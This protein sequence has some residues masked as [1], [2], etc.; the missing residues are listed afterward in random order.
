MSTPSP[1]L[2]ALTDDQIIGL[3]S[4]A[5]P[6]AVASP[7]ATAPDAPVAPPPSADSP[8]PAPPQPDPAPNPPADAEAFRQLYPGGIAEARAAADRARQLDEIDT[9]YFGANSASPQDLSAARAQLAQKLFAQDPA[10]FR[11]MVAA[12]VKLLESSSAPRSIAD[13]LAPTPSA[14]SPAAPQNSPALA[15]QLAQQYSAFER[16]ANADLDRSIGSSISRT[17]EQ[18]LPNLAHRSASSSPG[19]APLQ[20]RLASAVREELDAALR[21]DSQLGDQVSRVLASRRFDDSSRAQVVRLIDSRAQ[22]LVPTVVRRVVSDWT[23]ATLTPRL[24][25]TTSS[26]PAASPQSAPPSPAQ[27]SSPSTPSRPQSTS[28]APPPRSR[29]QRPDYSTLSDE[30]ILDL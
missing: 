4:S 27:P 28:S 10:A 25:T 21:S 11:E 24:P 8:S 17:L 15:P 29:S 2:F 3:D 12:G 9:V 6:S 26:A 16:A 18:A 5:D 13:P 7:L 20:D 1:E 23:Q 14:P 30:Q 22:Q 19:G